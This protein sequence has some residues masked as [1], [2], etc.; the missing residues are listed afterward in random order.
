MFDPGTHPFEVGHLQ[1]KAH[2]LDIAADDGSGIAMQIAA[3]HDD[4]A[5]D[6]SVGTERHVA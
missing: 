3:D 4:V 1:R 6:A 2:L 5:V